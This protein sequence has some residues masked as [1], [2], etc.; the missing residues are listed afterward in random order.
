MSNVLVLFNITLSQE[1][2]LVSCMIILFS[3]LAITRSD[4]GTYITWDVSL[5]IANGQL[6]LLRIFAGTYEAVYLLYQP[7]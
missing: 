5:V 6:I 7:R 1:G 4:I 3:L 2:H